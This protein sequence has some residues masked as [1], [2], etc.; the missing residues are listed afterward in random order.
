MTSTKNP[1]NFSGGSVKTNRYLRKLTEKDASY[2][3]VMI[4]SQKKFFM[5]KD[6]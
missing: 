4:V 3:F 1:T 2:T 5:K 6:I